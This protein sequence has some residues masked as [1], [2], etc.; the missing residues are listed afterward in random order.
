MAMFTRFAAAAAALGLAA[1]TTPGAFTSTAEDFNETVARAADSQLLLNIVR[2]ANRNP[3]H[4]AA[5]TI[6]RD[7]R[8]IGGTA[9]A[10]GQVPF[11]PDA[12]RSYSIA[13]ALS[14]TGSL[15]PSFD[16]VPL[17]NRAAAEGLFHPIDDQV[18]T[19]YW[20]HGWPRM[21][22]LFLFV[23]TI[24]LDESAK[25]ACGLGPKV[26]KAIPNNAA[27]FELAHA[28]FQCIQD[29]IEAEPS[30]S[31]PII[32]NASIPM[33]ALIRSLPDLSKNELKV[34][35]NFKNH[36]RRYS[37]T[38]KGDDFEL[39]LHLGPRV[40]SLNAGQGKEKKA[41]SFTLRS[42]DSMIYYLGELVR[43]Q[44]EHKCVLT[45][46]YYREDDKLKLHPELDTLFYVD[47]NQA[48]DR[49]NYVTADFLGLRYSISRMRNEKDHSLSVLSVV[50]QL[51]SLYREEK[52]LP[53]TS[54]VEVV[55]T[56]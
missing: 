33:S 26:P 24:T 7:S 20:K 10:S 56:R 15:A 52:E 36:Q 38:K 2:A 51:F 9:S 17:D 53:K 46:I 4:Y 55:G 3:T 43:W 12:L 22:L 8:S 23:D 25:R 32:S 34:K 18:F 30:S 11:G 14:A 28:V 29:K 16:Y 40:V 35:E 37:I 13:P 1:C 39:K 49:T 44:Q 54:A 21:V 47:V 42:V 19:T 41:I 31:K 6:V 27:H 45:Y 5:I 48:A 50:S